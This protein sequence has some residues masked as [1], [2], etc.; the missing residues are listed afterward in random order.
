MNYIKK[1][2][3][4]FVENAEKKQRPIRLMILIFLLLLSGILFAKYFLAKKEVS[5]RTK[6]IEE[7]IVIAESIIATETT[8]AEQTVDPDHSYIPSQIKTQERKVNYPEQS[9]LLLDQLN[10]RYETD[11]IIA[12]LDTGEGGI[13]EIIAFDPDSD[14]YDRRDIK[15][16]YDH[17]GTVFLYKENN[18]V[19]DDYTNYFGHSMQDGTRLK[20]LVDYEKNKELIESVKLYTYDG[21]LIYELVQ[22]VEVESK[23]YD[24]YKTWE[25]ADFIEFYE[26]SAVEGNLIMRNQSYDPH[27]KYM[28]LNTCQDYSGKIKTVA[29]YKLIEIL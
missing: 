19:L 28:T 1:N 9:K 4:M 26:N 5:K 15:G 2:E 21:I 13:R 22:I 3:M 29:I 20:K 8:Y 10:E 24:K 7:N 14:Y 12:F 6:D 25:Q 23:W 16:N 17:S 11:K 18:S 27:S